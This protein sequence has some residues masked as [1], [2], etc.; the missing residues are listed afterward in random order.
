M[1]YK[2]T[3]Y[4]V[5]IILI[6]I[7]IIKFNNSIKSKENYYNDEDTNRLY[8]YNNNNWLSYVYELSDNNYF[9]KCDDY[10][11][12][13]KNPKC[14]E[15]EIYNDF[16]MLK[17]RIKNFDNLFIINETNKKIYIKNRSY[18]IIISNDVTGDGN[19]YLPKIPSIKIGLVPRFDINNTLFIENGNKLANY[20]KMY[21]FSGADEYLRKIC[22]GNEI[23]WEN[24]LNIN[25][26]NAVNKNMKMDFNIY[27]KQISFIKNITL[28]LNSELKNE[29][30]NNVKYDIS[31][32]RHNSVKKLLLGEYINIKGSTDIVPIVDNILLVSKTNNLKIGDILIN[33]LKSVFTLLDQVDSMNTVRFNDIFDK[34]KIINLNTIKNPQSNITSPQLVT[35]IDNKEL[36]VYVGQ[37]DDKFKFFKYF[38]S[39][40]QTIVGANSSQN[41][42]FYDYIVDLDTRV[43]VLNYYF[44]KNP[45][46]PNNQ[47]VALFPNKSVIIGSSDKLSNYSS[48]NYIKINT[49]SN[50]NIYTINKNIGN[51]LNGWTGGHGNDNPLVKR[52]PE[53]CMQLADKQKKPAW[54]YRNYG[55]PLKDW[56]N[57]CMYYEQWFKDTG[58]TGND[59]DKAHILACTNKDKKVLQGCI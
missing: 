42:E 4:R 3:C 18:E 49:E 53:E 19:I 12:N 47:I 16:I 45:N 26:L 34:I 9:I 24:G 27:E 50:L 15:I 28:Y 21:Y 5:L 52:T 1:Y 48:D 33:Y 22:L 51:V 17:K 32:I 14:K 13:L 40:T 58:F 38:S 41:K 30:T 11:V 35:S 10:E 36:G 20:I 56:R 54:G 55:H 31:N 37:N 39:G 25:Y 29:R 43:N 23:T 57:T 7:F 59:S 46:D 8:I 44:I 2:K 6:I